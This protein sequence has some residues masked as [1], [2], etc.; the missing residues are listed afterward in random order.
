M[1][2]LLDKE[3]LGN[4]T[5]FAHLRHLRSLVPGI[6]EDVLKS[7]WL[8]HLPNQMAAFL[9][10]DDIVD[11]DKMATRAD[12]LYEIFNPGTIPVV[13]A[14]GQPS[15]ST[16]DHQIAELTKKV[17]VLTASF[18]KFRSRSH[19]P[20]RAS[21]RGRRRS[22]SQRRLPPNVDICW[23]HKKYGNDARSC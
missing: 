7:K 16:T 14:I 15:T 19:G 21:T 13:A 9:T 12:R 17:A 4:R 6:D 23:Y 8:S 18:N 20:A 22:S 1:R 11:L 5:P 3:A 10:E 2:Q